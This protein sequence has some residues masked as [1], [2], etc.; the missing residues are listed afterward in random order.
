MPEPRIHHS[1]R[2]FSNRIHVW[3][4]QLYYWE[5]ENCQKRRRRSNHY[6]YSS[7]SSFVIVLIINQPNGQLKTIMLL[8][9]NDLFSPLASFLLMKAASNCK[10]NGLIFVIIMYLIMIL[11]FL[12]KKKIMILRFFQTFFLGLGLLWEGP[13]NFLIKE[14]IS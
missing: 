13:L 8:N 5:K 4:F 1:F 3:N 9:I 6:I 7:C 11:R 2:R 12:Q 14:T 10:S